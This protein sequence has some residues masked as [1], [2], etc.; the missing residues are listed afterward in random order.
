MLV[1]RVLT[2]IDPSRRLL[3]LSDREICRPNAELV[4]ISHKMQA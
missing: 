2:S 1:E 4:A 3:I